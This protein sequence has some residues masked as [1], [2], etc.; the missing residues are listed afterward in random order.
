[1]AGNQNRRDV[2]GNRRDGYKVTENGKT[3]STAKTQ[4]AAEAQAKAQVDR[5]GGGQVYIHRPDG[6]IRDAD[7]V[8]PGNESSARD[9]KH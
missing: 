4:A 5:A 8:T 1:M 7:T 6:K 9:T 3:T 2:S